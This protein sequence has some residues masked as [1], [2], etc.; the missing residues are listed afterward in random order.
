[1][2]IIYFNIKKSNKN[3]TKGD[4]NNI[5]FISELRKWLFKSTKTAP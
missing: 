1:M 3:K 2:K 5:C 4:V